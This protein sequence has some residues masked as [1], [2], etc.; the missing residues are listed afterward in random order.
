VHLAEADPFT[1]R[2]A[3]DRW[4]AD[5]DRAVLAAQVFSY[6]GAAHFYTDPDLADYHPA[7]TTLTW[8]RV[9]AFLS[10]L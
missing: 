2:R 10:T 4:Q 8:Q 6:P 5:A 7:S 9:I 3:V 1:S